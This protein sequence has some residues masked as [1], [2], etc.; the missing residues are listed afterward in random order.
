[1]LTNH[2]FGRHSPEQGQV[3]MATSRLVQNGWGKTGD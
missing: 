3:P 1:M 2:K